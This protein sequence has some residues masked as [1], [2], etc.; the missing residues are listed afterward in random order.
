MVTAKTCLSKYGEPDKAGS[1]MTLWDVPADLEIGVIP[2][3]IYC[4]L[5]LVGPLRQVFINLVSRGYAESELLTWDGCFNI[6]Q[7]TGGGSWSLHSWGIAID[8]N[9]FANGYGKKPQ[10]SAGFV[11]CFTSAGFD[12]GGEWRIPDGMHFQLSKI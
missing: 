4:N 10:L 2:K 8:L 1:W 5:D 9:A 7:T 11:E 12:W 3:R 6:R